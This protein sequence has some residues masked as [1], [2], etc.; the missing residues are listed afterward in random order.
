MRLLVRLLALVGLATVA[1]VAGVLPAVS[2]A[3]RPCKP[4]VSSLLSAKSGSAS[5]TGLSVLNP[6][7][8]WE[9]GFVSPPS[10]HQR[11]LV[12]H[13]DGGSWTK[14]TIPPAGGIDSDL[15]GVSGVA[16]D[17]VWATGEWV[18]KSGIIRTLVDHWNGTSWSIVPS[19][20][21][22]T[23]SSDLSAVS[24]DA[25]D[26]AWAVGLYFTGTGEQPLAEH[27]TGGVWSIHAMPAPTTY[28]YN[29]GVYADSPTDAW[30]VGNTASSIYSEHWNG[31]SWHLVATAAV[32]TPR[33]YTNGMSGSG[34]DDVWLGGETDDPVTGPHPLVEHWDG[35]AW[36][37]SLSS[38]TAGGYITAIDALGPGDVW[39]A[40]EN[41][42][43]PI[44]EH[45][46]G[47]SW[48][49]FP[50]TTSTGTY[51]DAVAGGGGQVFLGGDDG[52]GSLRVIERMC[53]LQLTDTGFSPAMVQVPLG[54]AELWSLPL[55][56]LSNHTVTDAS[57]ASAFGSASLG[58]GSSYTAFLPA[59]T[60]S[61]SDP[62]SGGKET[63]RVAPVATP[64]AGGVSTS[65]DLQIA[66]STG[67][68]P[69]PFV[70][71]VQ[72]LRPGTTTW[73]LLAT[74]T[75]SDVSFTPDAG[76][77]IYKLR[78]RVRNTSLHKQSLWSP[79]ASI[80]VS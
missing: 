5:V 44:L 22:G 18:P 32:G 61:V 79:A 9:I 50:T 51:L 41:S 76:T 62:T 30:V 75:A 20:S 2:G 46:D 39:A 65:F 60:Y 68:P 4:Y 63:V 56:N 57:G 6:G 71:D 47:V 29:E 55:S 45:W 42:G 54:D 43:V 48:T 8:A 72:V 14:A 11:P 77:G 38:T 40:G 35:S 12:E 17:D 70:L 26:D 66:P 59:G 74:T 25:A 31:T 49:S 34:P 52:G 28:S 67:P 13:W 36:S 53:P 23:D 24:A 15:E 27:Y 73:S 58:P 1:V 7:D 37:V 80:S 10:G 69:G 19:P 3:T 16:S 78:V 21:K 64:K 33:S